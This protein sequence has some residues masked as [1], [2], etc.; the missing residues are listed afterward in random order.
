MNRSRPATATIVVGVAALLPVVMRD[1]QTRTDV[2]TALALFLAALGLWAAVGVGGLPSLGQGAF[3]GLGAYGTAML[4]VHDG[5]N[6]LVASAAGTVVAGTAG[7]IVA[8]G[9]ARF[10]PAFVA[11]ATLLASWTF[12]LAVNAFPGLTG[13]AAGLVV[14][15]PVLESRALG[16]RVTVGPP[17]RYEIALLAVVVGALALL[18]LGRRYRAAMT[19]ARDDS[20]A[21]RGAGIPVERLRAG[22]LVASAVVGGAAGSLLVQLDGVADPTRYG[23][24]LSVKLFI[25]VVLG[26]QL[27]ALGLGLMGGA[28]SAAGP[29]VGLAALVVVDR[30][31]HALA[32]AFGGSASRLEPLAAGATLLVVLLAAGTPAATWW[33]RRRRSGGAPD[34]VRSDATVPPI[35]GLRLDGHDLAVSFG[36]VD[37][38]TGVDIHV[39]SGSC[40]AVIGPNGSGKTTL[41][42]VLAGVVSPARGTVRLADRDVTRTGPTGRRRAGLARSL[43][44]P[45]LAPGLSVMTHVVAATEATRIDGWLRS[46]LATPRARAERRRIEADAARVLALV[47]LAQDAASDV[48][49]LDGLARRLLQVAMALAGGSRVVLLDEPSAGLREPEE[50][51]LVDVLVRL[52]DAG[53]TIVVV[54]HNLRL[55]AALADEVTVLDAGQVIARGRPDDVMREPAVLVAYVGDPDDS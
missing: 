26:A 8:V 28:A 29:A 18:A 13:G 6:P 38:L 10:R 3:V 25:V 1:G 41:L 53:M 32:R 4:R 39:A 36:G 2:A 48:A 7:V 16:I 40:H 50:A 9:V 14:P 17:A 46:L 33:T 34:S 44:R 52:R 12:A 55:V 23:P 54:E 24:L 21:A 19:V 11:L 30:V 47:G 20:A 15:D 42:R 51:R 45:A 27:L 31:G 5:W 37:A 43:Q 49:Q 35:G 22:A